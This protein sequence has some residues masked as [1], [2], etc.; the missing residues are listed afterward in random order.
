MAGVDEQRVTNWIHD[1]SAILGAREIGSSPAETKI[2]QG[3]AAILRHLPG[4]VEGG[5]LGSP[6]PTRV[7]EMLS[8]SDL[9]HIAQALDTSLLILDRHDR[10]LTTAQRRIQI[11]VRATRRYATEEL[12][13]RDAGTFTCRA[14]T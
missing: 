2:R 6:H 7:T 3:F 13:L 4:A 14:G 5:R 8:R 10:A 12:N 9:R 1:A 11:L